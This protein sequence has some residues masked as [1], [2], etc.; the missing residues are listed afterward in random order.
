MDNPRAPK[1]RVAF[2]IGAAALALLFVVALRSPS[3]HAA[4]Q[5]FIELRGK[6]VAASPAVLSDHEIATL[7]EMT[8]QQQAERLLE[9]AVNHYSGEI[10]RAHV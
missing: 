5:A 1:L 7:A 8:P 2:L 6:P 10:G 4:W 9:R 3:V